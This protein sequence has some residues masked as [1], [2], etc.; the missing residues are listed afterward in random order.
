MIHDE[1]RLASRRTAGRRVR[2]G[3]E[4]DV[5]ERSIGNDHQALRSTQQVRHRR[6]EPAGEAGQG[7][8][9]LPA[10]QS[11]AAGGQEESGTASFGLQHLARRQL[12]AFDRS[13]CQGPEE[14]ALSAQVVLKDQGPGLSDL[15]LDLSES[16][17]W[18]CR[19]LGGTGAGPDVGLVQKLE[20]CARPRFFAGYQSPRI[21]VKL[22]Q[23][24]D[25]EPIDI[26]SGGK[27]RLAQV[28]AGR[29]AAKL[30]DIARSAFDGS[31]GCLLPSCRAP[32]A[33]KAV[34]GFGLLVGLTDLG[35][36]SP[37]SR[38][39][40]LGLFQTPEIQIDTAK[41]DEGSSLVRAVAI[42][43][44][45]RERLPEDPLRLGDLSQPAVIPAK[46]VES[47]GFSFPVSGLALE[48][49]R[50]LEGRHDLLPGPAT[51]S[52]SHPL[53]FLGPA[54]PSEVP[55]CFQE[56]RRLAEMIERLGQLGQ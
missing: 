33:R 11:M 45:D 15:S 6:E 49:E 21:M 2:Q 3:G 7:E 12:E 47:H 26:L 16:Y 17:C 38:E 35:E 5:P 20:E 56:S 13:G 50:A 30:L 27:E 19:N 9:G 34:Q 31:Q 1:R 18:G 28:R 24:I 51:E 40:C 4:G 37:R 41:V 43:L 29:F 52:E 10:G 44:E 46:I 48:L 8:L 55:E 23:E 25:A 36:Q 54:E 39:G 42:R 22:H 32:N 53:P 14:A